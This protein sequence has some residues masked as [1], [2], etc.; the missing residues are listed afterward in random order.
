[1]NDTPWE[2]QSID[3]VGYTQGNWFVF[4]LVR[5]SFRLRS[6]PLT[7]RTRKQK[8][9]K[10][11]VSVLVLSLL[12]YHDND[13]SQVDW[14]V[15]YLN[16]SSVQRALRGP[17]LIRVLDIEIYLYFKGWRQEHFVAIRWY[18]FDT[19]HYKLDQNLRV[20]LA[21]DASKRAGSPEGCCTRLRYHG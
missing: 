2:D 12:S 16:T 4:C 14:A 11:G 19:A 21:D 13:S 7:S 3:V 5:Y 15:K 10:S 1:M 6:T 8:N 18:S 20:D 9:S 17:L